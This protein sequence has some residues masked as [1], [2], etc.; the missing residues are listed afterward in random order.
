MHPSAVTGAKEAYVLVSGDCG[1]WSAGSDSLQGSDDCAWWGVGGGGASL[2]WDS[3]MGGKADVTETGL[4]A[5]A[6]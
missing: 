1:S 5:A 4:W 3:R 6:G 2:C